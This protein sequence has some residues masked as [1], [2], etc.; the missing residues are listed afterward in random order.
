MGVTDWLSASP[1]SDSETY[2]ESGN[3][4]SMTPSPSRLARPESQGASILPTHYDT[5]SCSPPGR[6]ANVRVGTAGESGRSGIHP[7]HFIV[8]CFKS[9]C[10]LSMLVNILWPFVPAAFA[11]HFASP[12]FH[13]SVFA[14][15]YVAMVPAANLLGFSGAELA[16]KLPK[17][18][19]ILLETMWSSVVEIVLFIVLVSKDR[20]GNLVP[21]VQ[22]AILGSI[23]A[24]LLLCLGLCFFLGGIGRD[25]QVFHRVISEVGSGLMLVAGFGLLIPSTFNAALSGMTKPD[26]HFTA[27]ML[28]DS[29]LKISRATAVILLVSFS[30]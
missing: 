2:R 18:P 9:T 13:V 1:A 6:P 5:S 3:A 15:N 30:M 27:G 8:V 14:L 12:E 29:T 11:L 20:G 21:V 19:G 22:A 23:L 25:E 26:S 4:D 28:S 7:I 17:T 24:N 10:T 16:K